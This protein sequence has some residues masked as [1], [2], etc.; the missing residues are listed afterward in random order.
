MMNKLKKDNSD[1]ICQFHQFNNV[2][3]SKC[4]N[5]PH[6]HV[7]PKYLAKEQFAKY[8]NSLPTRPESQKYIQ[9]VNGKFLRYAQ[10]VD[11]TLLTPLSALASQ[12]AKPTTETTKQVK[13]F[14][15]IAQH[16]SQ[17]S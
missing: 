7:E 1:L 14:W 3:P 13:Q 6:P 12:Q 4:Q 10:G 9:K 5:S 2:V 17:Q 8:D 16:M 11:G 15:I